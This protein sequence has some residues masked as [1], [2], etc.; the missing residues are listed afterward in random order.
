MSLFFEMLTN[1][2]YIYIFVSEFYF[3]DFSF[4]LSETVKTK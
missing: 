1:R 3:D 2:I 4:E